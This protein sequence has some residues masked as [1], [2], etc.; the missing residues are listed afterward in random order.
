MRRGSL[1]VGILVSLAAIAGLS[2]WLGGASA[3]DQ[4][5]ILI[6]IDSLRPD[7]LGVHSYDRDT[8]PAID[9]LAAAGVVFEDAVSTS[10]WTLPAHASLLTSLPPEVHGAWGDR[11]ALSETVPL[12]SEVFQHA[13]WTTFG[14]V[15]APYLESRFGYGRGWHIY[16]DQ[17]VRFAGN[18]DSHSGVTSPRLHERALE[19]LDAALEGDDPLFLFLHYWDVHFDYE[20]PPPYDTLFDPDYSGT[21]DGRDFANNPAIHPDMDPRDLE[22]IIALYDGEIRWVDHHLGLLFDALRERGLFENSLIV[23]TADH[24]DEFFEH[25]LTGHRANLFDSTLRIPLVI[26]FPRGRHAGRRVAGT[27][28]LTDVAPT[29][30]AAMDLDP[31]ASFQGVDLLRRLGPGHERDGEPRFAHLWSRREEHHAI[32]DGPLKWIHRTL[33]DSRPDVSLYDRTAPSPELHDQKQRWPAKE[34]RYESLHRERQAIARRLAEALGGGE[35]E[36]S[37][38]LVRE[39]ES[40]GYL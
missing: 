24:G 32:V 29:V 19:L 26:K 20:P 28:S 3:Q 1:I 5:V 21:L 38:E 35:I 23:V 16:D 18:F 2:W 14:L 27:V 11:R 4:S 9:A 40:L 34:R 7:H 8:S 22:H 36:Y 30:L 12:L 33:E 25:G 10:S 15:S 37:P 13:G 39:L 17:T 31:P 6:S